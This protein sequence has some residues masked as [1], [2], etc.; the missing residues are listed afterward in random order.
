MHGLVIPEVG[1]GREGLDAVTAGEFLVGDLDEVDPKAGCVVVYTLELR[2]HLVAGGATA[3]VCRY[4]IKHILIKQYWAMAH[5][6][7]VTFS[8]TDMN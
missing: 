2:E 4:I 7:L 6:C 5:T 1:E 3:L 8:L